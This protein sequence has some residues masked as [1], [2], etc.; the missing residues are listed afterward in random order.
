[1]TLRR[2]GLSLLCLCA[3]GASACTREVG[4]RTHAWEG[5]VTAARTVMRLLWIQQGDVE[6]V[7]TGQRTANVIEEHRCKV[8]GRALACDDDSVTFEDC[9]MDS[10]NRYDGTIRVGDGPQGEQQFLYEG[11]TGEMNGNPFS[12]NGGYV[13]VDNGD[14]SRTITLDQTATGEDVGYHGAFTT[15]ATGTFTFGADDALSGT[16]TVAS[17]YEIGEPSSTTCTFESM[18]IADFIAFTEGAVAFES[19]CP[20]PFDEEFLIDVK[21]KHRNSRDRENIHILMPGESYSEDQHVRPGGTRNQKWW[22]VTGE[23]M[24]ISAGR[25]GTMFTT[26]TCP[27]SD[28]AGRGL[29]AVY[30]DGFGLA[31]YS[32]YCV[33]RGDDAPSE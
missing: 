2:P 4:P 31:T 15:V 11:F 18:P 17:T 1:M 9:V 19:V 22:T 3:I 12:L 24:V 13:T 25:G 14:G 33:A 7:R 30:D 16:M 26:A 28:P 32:L 21:L 6:W 27:P 8:R 20:Q 10:E 29:E 23:E 5:E